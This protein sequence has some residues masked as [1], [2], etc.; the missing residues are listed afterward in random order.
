MAAMIFFFFCPVCFMECIN[1]NITLSLNFF[2]Q[3]SYIDVGSI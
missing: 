1:R 3:S 2:M